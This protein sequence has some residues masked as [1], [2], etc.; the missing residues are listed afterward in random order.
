MGGSSE[1]FV[2]YNIMLEMRDQEM[3]AGSIDYNTHRPLIS[4][5]WYMRRSCSMK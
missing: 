5:V 3:A 2:E 4:V 1:L